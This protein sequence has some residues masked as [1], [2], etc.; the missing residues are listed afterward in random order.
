MTQARGFPLTPF[1]QKNK[2]NKKMV[3][4]FNSDHW[5]LIF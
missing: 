1:S 4:I 5:L 3:A 2:R